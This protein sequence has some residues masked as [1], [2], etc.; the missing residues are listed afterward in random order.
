MVEGLLASKS[1][2]NIYIYWGMPQSTAIYTDVATTW[3]REFDHVHYVPVISSEENAWVGR[4]GFV[5]QAVMDDFADL[6]A[7]HVY[8]CGSALMIAAAKAAFKS[9]GLDGAHFYSDAFVPSK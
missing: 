6:S 9:Q 3:A 1:S 8:A 4:I 5:H 7:Y 2:R